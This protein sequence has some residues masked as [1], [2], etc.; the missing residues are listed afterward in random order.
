M[1]SGRKLKDKIDKA[2][3]DLMLGVKPIAEEENLSKTVTNHKKE[4]KEIRNMISKMELFLKS[5]EKEVKDNPVGYASSSTSELKNLR[6][7]LNRAVSIFL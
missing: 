4:V 7:K 6:T 2:Y 5:K 1:I 3:E